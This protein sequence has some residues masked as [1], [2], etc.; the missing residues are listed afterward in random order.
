MRKVE[1]EEGKKRGNGNEKK[2]KEKE[3]S[4]ARKI[5][6][7]AISER[8]NET[9]EEKITMGKRRGGWG[10]RRGN[11]GDIELENGRVKRRSRGAKSRVRKVFYEKG[12]RWVVG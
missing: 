4:T 2:K 5:T 1:K 3:K 12:D 8:G 9:E 10:M 11:I 7:N 6:E